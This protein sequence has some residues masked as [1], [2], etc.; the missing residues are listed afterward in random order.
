[1]RTEREILREAIEFV[2]LTD[3]TIWQETHAAIVIP[4]VRKYS[5]HTTGA[6]RDVFNWEGGA[7]K[8]VPVKEKKV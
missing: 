7:W 1:M 2:S 5:F 8:R 4:G 3:N 6:L